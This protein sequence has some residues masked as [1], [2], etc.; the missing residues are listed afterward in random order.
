MYLSQ[1]RQ[2]LC[3]VQ[4]NF[5]F[6]NKDGIL[7]E[8]IP[9]WLWNIQNKSFSSTQYNYSSVLRYRYMFSS[10]TSIIRPSIKCFNIRYDAKQVHSL[11]GIPQVFN[12]YYNTKLYKILR[13][14]LYTILFKILYCNNYHQL[15]GTHIGNTTC[16]AFSLVLKIL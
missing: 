5:G 4:H 1:N 8:Y 7:M 15:V 12:N 6:H 2:E 10:F 16:I 9:L 13:S 3:P 11:C 14:Q